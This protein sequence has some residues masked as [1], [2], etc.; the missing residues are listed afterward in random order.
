MPPIQHI[1]KDVV[2]KIAADEAAQV[3]RFSSERTSTLRLELEL[4][5]GQLRESEKKLKVLTDRWNSMEDVE[6]RL[7]QLSAEAE[8]DNGV[9]ETVD[10]GIDQEKETDD[11]GPSDEQPEESD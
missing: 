4:T 10:E 5:S 9:A 1:P 2:I 7:E 8:D 3:A 6:A 11:V